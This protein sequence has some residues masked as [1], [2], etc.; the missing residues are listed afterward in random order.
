MNRPVMHTFVLHHCL[1]KFVI[2]YDTLIFSSPN[3]I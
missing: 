1:F 3:S 2:N